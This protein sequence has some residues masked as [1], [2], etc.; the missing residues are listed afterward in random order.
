MKNPKWILL[1]AALVLMAGAAGLLV[2]LRTHPR[3]GK[4]GIKAEPL[5]GTL[6]MEL[7]L[8][9]HV[10]EFVSTNVPEPQIVLGYLPSDSSFV[11]R[12]YMAPDGFNCTGTVILMGAD[13]TSIHNADYC[14]RGQGLTPHEKK[15]VNIPIAGP[16]PYELPV[17]EWKVSGVFQRPDGQ[18]FTA[19][20]VYVFWFTAGGAQTPSHRKMIERLA[21]HLVTTGVLQRWAYISYFAPCE[22][23]KEDA[24]FERMKKLIAASAPEFQLPPRRPDETVA[25]RK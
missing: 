20:G 13:R 4:P 25:K 8:P 17:S 24:A 21:A 10:L 11:S 14:L 2:R 16:R 12:D 5:P 15:I 18:R 23:G 6:A 3:L 9:K 1:V 19:A 7:E 22:P